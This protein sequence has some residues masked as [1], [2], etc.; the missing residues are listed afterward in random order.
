MFNGFKQLKRSIIMSITI[1]SSFKITNDIDANNSYII[2]I[3]SD[4]K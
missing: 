2:D 4:D 3:V 1:I